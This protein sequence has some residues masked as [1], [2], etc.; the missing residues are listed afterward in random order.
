MSRPP[1]PLKDPRPSIGGL[2]ADPSVRA[3][4][5]QV[6]RGWAIRD[7]IDAAEDAG[8]LALALERR[9]DERCGASSRSGWTPATHAPRDG[10]PDDREPA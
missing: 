2:L 1:I 5:K 3:P 9:A 10:G 4:L 8:L 7:P 6:L